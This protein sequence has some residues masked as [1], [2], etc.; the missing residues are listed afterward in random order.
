MPEL[1]R[2]LGIVVFMNFNEHNPPHFHAK[3]G[4]YEIIVEIIS[5]IVEGKFPRRALSL[6]ME[7]YGLHK[8]ELLQD[9]ESIRTTGE[10]KKIQPLE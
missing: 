1:S 5:G 9:W 10:F 4:D 8:D 3:Y 7:W 6:V 2:F